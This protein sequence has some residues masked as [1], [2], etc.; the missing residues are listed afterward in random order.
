MKPAGQRYRGVRLWNHGLVST[1]TDPV[2]PAASTDAS[3][4][5]DL[6]V[7][8]T[9]HVTP[10][11]P[12]WSAPTDEAEPA[13]RAHR[14]PPAAP[15]AQDGTADEA[16]Q[17]TRAHRLPTAGAAP[18]V[19]PTSP[20]P[21]DP[22]GSA[23]HAAAGRAVSTGDGWQIA[24]ASGSSP[25]APPSATAAGQEDR[26]PM[27]WSATPPPPAPRPTAPP[28]GGPRQAGQAPHP[29]APG[30]GQPPRGTNTLAILSLVFGLVGS[31]IIAVVLGH[32]ARKQI[33]LSGESGDGL[34]IA[35][36]ILGY[37]GLLVALAIIIVFI[38][39]AASVS[40]YS[41]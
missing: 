14:L 28:P 1:P 30:W 5:S 39:A 13:T 25:S 18:Q 40:A 24:P 36:L 2:E 27:A 37:L 12:R 10:A 22:A 9:R 23:P 21:A 35:G 16:D 34:A 38:V 20:A 15:V 33:R 7:P 41:Y 8:S 31:G 32:M 6:T 19:R 17:A 4:V 3:E 11:P 26:E 29:Q